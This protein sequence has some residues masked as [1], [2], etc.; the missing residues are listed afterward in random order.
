MWYKGINAKEARAVFDYDEERGVLIRKGSVYE[1]VNGRE[2]TGYNR[3]TGYRG[4]DYKGNTVPFHALVFVVHYGVD[5][6]PGYYVDHKDNDKDNNSPAN[7]RLV[8][9]SQNS[10][11]K[12]RSKT[13]NKSGVKGVGFYKKYNKWRA[14][15]TAHGKT[16]LAGYFDTIE[17]AEVAVRNL[18]EKLHGE[19]AN[20][21]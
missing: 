5:V 20:H 15:V 13:A 12:R 16:K 17:E 9:P 11:N 10:F 21:G 2:I 1:G 3:D 7:L 19:Y 18:R 6:P 14:R 4:V 8:S